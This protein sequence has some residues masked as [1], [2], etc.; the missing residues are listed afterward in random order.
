MG[1]SDDVEKAYQ[2]ALNRFEIWDARLRPSLNIGKIV[3]E[4]AHDPLSELL[5]AQ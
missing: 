2:R 1:R 5:R 4:R 3:P